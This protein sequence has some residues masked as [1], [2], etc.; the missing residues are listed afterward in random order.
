[1]QR[2]VAYALGIGPFRASFRDSK[3]CSQTQQERHETGAPARQTYFLTEPTPA[4]RKTLLACH[5]PLSA[6]VICVESQCNAFVYKLS[7]LRPFPERFLPLPLK[8]EKSKKC[9]NSIKN[10][11]RKQ[12]GSEKEDQHQNLPELTDVLDFSKRMSFENR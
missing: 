10:V 9:V 6:Q 7:N 2:Y 12:K 4:F 1:V 5:L 3:R 11:Y 8:F